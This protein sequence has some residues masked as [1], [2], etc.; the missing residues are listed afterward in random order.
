MSELLFNQSVSI[1]SYRKNNINFAATYAWFTQVGYSEF[2]G[3]LGNQSDTAHNLNVGDIVGLS[4][5]EKSQIDI[6]NILGENHS[7]KINKLE[8]IKY[9]IEDSAIFIDNAKSLIKLK[10]IDILHL[11]GIKEDYLV[12][13]KVLSFK[14]NNGEFL[15]MSDY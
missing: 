12:Y 5:L 4:V 1:L 6:A 10:V 8:N 11:E 9:S 14:T 7:L 13:F 15:T 2:M 3:L